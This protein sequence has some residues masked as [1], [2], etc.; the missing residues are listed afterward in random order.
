M[1]RIGSAVREKAV[2]KMSGPHGVDANL[3]ALTTGPAP[4]FR[5]GRIRGQNMAQELVERSEPMQYPA[6]QVYCEKIENRLTEK[7]RAFS[8]GVRL[9]V[10]VR[11]S[12]DRV[13]GIEE[14]VE[15]YVEAVTRVLASSRGDWGDGMFYGGG[16]EVSFGA[17]KRGGRNFIQAA[18]ISFEI[19]VSRN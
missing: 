7:F 14:V 8:G 16:Y 13:E 19:G 1:T 3:A 2:Q 4:V 5:V 9:A 11:H 18:K 10:E 17:V 6:V 12:Q 15:L